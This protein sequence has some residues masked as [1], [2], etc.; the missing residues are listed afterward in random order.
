MAIASAHC[1]A[2]HPSVTMQASNLH[3][4]ANGK[5]LILAVPYSER[6]RERERE[7][8]Q[9]GYARGRGKSIVPAF[10]ALLLFALTD[11]GIDLMYSFSL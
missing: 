4:V 9:H 11:G 7:K 6:E 5:I 10:A 8:K 1:F 2:G 3:A